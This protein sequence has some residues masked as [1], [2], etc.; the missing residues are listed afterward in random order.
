MSEHILI[1]DD[2][3]VQRRLLEAAVRRMGHEPTMAE[4]GEAALAALEGAQDKPFRLVILDLMMPGLDGLQV[5]D[6][7]RQRG[8]ALPV[9]VQTAQ[10]SIDTVI[11]AMRAGAFDFVVK[12]VAPER[13]QVSVTNAL[14]VDTLKDQA[15]KTLIN[16]DANLHKVFDKAQVTMFEMTKLINNHLK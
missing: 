10:G 3:P 1:V 13:L 4:G 6:A 9:I 14:K 11:S 16:A 12:P 15:K 8:F 2:D 5:M 7:M